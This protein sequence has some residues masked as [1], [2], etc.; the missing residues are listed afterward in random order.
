MIPGLYDS[1]RTD[2]SG[3]TWNM[4]L[5][6]L[7]SYQY[8]PWMQNMIDPK[9]GVISFIPKFEG[10]YEAV[11]VATDDRGASSVVEFTLFCAQEGTWLNHPP[12]IIKDWDHPQTVK[13]GEQI[14]LTTPEIKV[15]DPDGDELY[16]S[17]NI[18]SC[19]K[20][21]NGD[22]MWT[23]YTHFPGFYPVEIV[24]YDIRGGYAVVRIDLEVTPW[25]SF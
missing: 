21:P 7:P 14:I 20:R 17:C 22:F 16:Y 4:T 10:A 12:I 23:F 9:T 24:A 2:M 5:N 3:I 18:G 15:I 13:A 25:W 11:V 1:I 8:G 6:G 19:G